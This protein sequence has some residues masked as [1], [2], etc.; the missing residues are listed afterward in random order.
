MS[1]P[2]PR[3][4]V[5][6]NIE[7]PQISPRIDLRKN[8][9][10]STFKKM[11]EVIY[12][13][14]SIIGT[15]PYKG[16][17]LRV[18]TQPIPEVGSWLS[19]FHNS[20][21]GKD[22]TPKLVQVKVRIPEIHSMLPVP[23]TLGQ[24]SKDHNIIDMYPTFIAQSTDVPSPGIGSLVWV[25]FG[26]KTNFTDPI[27]V[28]PVNTQ[29][30]NPS[31]GG[32]KS[33]KELH[34]RIC[35]NSFSSIVPS[36]D[37][38][39]GGNKQISVI[40][41]PLNPRRA[42][43][44][45]SKEYSSLKGLRYSALKL[46]KWDKSIRNANVPGKTWI[47]VLN[48]NGIED[49]KNKN[50]KRN[51]IIFSPN[52]TDFTV[53]VELIYFFHGI[54]EFGDNYDFEKR[55][56]QGIKKL[57][58]SG[59]NFVIV[60]PE[61]PWSIDSK[62][63]D[64]DAWVDN[65]NF[66]DFH[67]EIKNI[68]VKN[69]SNKINIEFITVI[70]YSGGGRAIKNA[71]I[72]GFENVKPNR[73][74][75]ADAS[76]KDYAQST[77]DNYVSKNLNVEFDLLV[78]DS[79][80][81][82]T[83]AKTLYDKISSNKNVLFEIIKGKNHKEI[84]DLAL[85]Y[86]SSKLKEEK[87]Q[88]E[89]DNLD[90]AKQEVDVDPNTQEPMLE[91]NSNKQYLNQPSAKMPLPNNNNIAPIGIAK[92]QSTKKPTT[93]VLKQ[94]VP[95]TEAR[96]RVEDYSSLGGNENILVEYPCSVSGRKALIHT[97][98]AKRLDLLNNAWMEEN[99]GVE[100]I[101][102]NN[103]WRKQRFSTQAEYEA[104]LF[105]KYNGNINEGKK[106]IAFSSP[107]QTGMAIDIGNNGLQPI[108]TTNNQQKQTKLYK[109][110]QNNAHKFGF[111]PYLQ[112][113]WHFE[114]RLP[115]EAWASGEEFTDNYAVMVE[116]PGEGG[117]VPDSGTIG[118]NCVMALGDLLN[119]QGENL[120]M[121]ARLG[122]NFPGS[123]NK[124]R[125]KK[126]IEELSVQL[127][128]E[129][130]IAAAFAR[131]ESGGRSGFSS[132]GRVIIKF[133]PHVF[134]NYAK[135]FK[136]LHSLIPWSNNATSHMIQKWE[137][138]GKIEGWSYYSNQE[139]QYK[140]LRYA[141][142]IHEELA[143]Y[144]IS[145]GMFQIMG[146]NHRKMGYSTAKNLFLGFQGSEELQLRSFFTFVTKT[147]GL[148]AALKDKDYLKAARLYNGKGKEVLYAQKIKNN[149]DIFKKNGIG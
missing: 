124:D 137:D 74:I 88:E 89:L 141:I 145:S 34:D 94:A 67:K 48:N 35:P 7:N 6:N 104:F 18:D 135:S 57:S 27:Y 70:G 115:K 8:N 90:L 60:I 122:N 99:P 108:S 54:K 103:G 109:W 149:Y 146:F 128:L 93:A 65:D 14:N 132:D 32:S 51:T 136:V 46:K 98:V 86:L 47:G 82:F 52:V 17:V 25:D 71:A 40:G 78:Q 24:D 23:E 26:N 105:Q 79:G 125:K 58:D 106:W 66:D 21:T 142:K 12:T 87:E 69:Y 126:L 117:H 63:Y 3:H 144:S 50:G 5:L 20:I 92:S 37:V 30:A 148:L 62:E 129:P 130:E 75:F 41:L 139:G 9:V 4:G 91:D 56:S 143:Y 77:W 44:N 140:A 39:A 100:R 147:S 19:N 13:P 28:K 38:I 16:I 110:L 59:R 127:G 80:A 81:T 64:R 53:P 22:S 102:I 118:D 123:L 33:A 2:Y 95:F 112:E 73:I 133:E 10:V 76:Y 61:L 131:I 97:L 1:H 111:S 11:V 49:Y 85:N 83:N 138:L 114:C 120:D 36:G 15:G 121:A 113:A 119:N 42:K 107:H 29:D 116:N 43:I 68:L 134:V 72:K 84:G 101:K 45:I 55:Y 31:S 96:I